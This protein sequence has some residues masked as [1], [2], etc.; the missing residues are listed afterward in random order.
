MTDPPEGTSAACSPYATSLL[1]VPTPDHQWLLDLV[2][3]VFVNYGNWPV[4]DFVEERIEDQG[5]VADELLTSLP[6]LMSGRHR[7]WSYA[8]VKYAPVHPPP[9]DSRVALTVLG[10]ALSKQRRDIAGGCIQFVRALA[11][12]KRESPFDPTTV[13]PALP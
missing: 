1:A 7:D 13:S 5:L 6:S 10:L 3:E 9:R 12:A 8:A 2:A 11:T 4:Y